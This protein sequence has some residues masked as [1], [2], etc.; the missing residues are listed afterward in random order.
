MNT[1]RLTS[2]M[3][4][5]LMAS[6]RFDNPFFGLTVDWVLPLLSSSQVRVPARMSMTE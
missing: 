3:P 5:T 4:G 6:N 1:L 2:Q